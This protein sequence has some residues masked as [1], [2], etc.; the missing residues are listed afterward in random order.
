MG[1][2]FQL[3]ICGLAIA[4]LFVPKRVLSGKINNPTHIIFFGLAQIALA[5]LV[6]VYVLSGAL[7]NDGVK[8]GF[9]VFIIVVFYG[10][11]AVYGLL[12]A[13]L[14]AIGM[15]KASAHK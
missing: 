7:Q 12:G 8:S 5:F 10:F 2:I 13:G 9:Q 11:C 14:V 4:L 6:W 15:I 3:L 1:A